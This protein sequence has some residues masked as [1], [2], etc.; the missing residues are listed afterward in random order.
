MRKPRGFSSRPDLAFA[1]CQAP[2]LMTFATG[3]I[4]HAASQHLLMKVKEESDKS[5]LKLNIEKMKIIP[6]DPILWQIDGENWKSC[7][8]P[9]SWVLKS[10]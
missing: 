10:M 7:Q 8:N 3:G 1:F 5:V 4:P 9:F 2:F 6:S